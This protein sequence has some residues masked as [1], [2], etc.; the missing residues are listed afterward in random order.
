[1]RKIGW[2]LI[3][4]LIPLAAGAAWAGEPAS[5]APETA[6]VANTTAAPAALPDELAAQLTPKP[7][8]KIGFKNG[9]CTVSVSCIGGITISCAGQSYCTW[10]VD[11]LRS[12]GFVE[13]D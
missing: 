4:A 9:P 2:L 12:R 3:C 10:Q 6:G 8:N 5:P 1:M 13:C 11:S 7:E